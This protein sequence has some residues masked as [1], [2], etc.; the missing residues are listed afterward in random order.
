MSQKIALVTGG[1][2]GIGRA[3]AIEL[4]NQGYQVFIT[5]RKEVELL[6][7]KNSAKNPENI[8][9]IVVDFNKSGFEKEI[10]SFIKKSVGE[11]VKIDRLIHCAAI[12]GPIDKLKN[13]ESRLAESMHVNAYA[14][15]ILTHELLPLCNPNT[16]G[17]F[18][19]SNFM[20]P[21]KITPFI[22]IFGAYISSKIVLLTCIILSYPF[23]KGKISIEIPTLAPV[24]DTIIY[25]YFLIKRLQILVNNSQKIKSSLDQ[26]KST[27]LKDETLK[28]AP[29]NK[30][31]TEVVT[32]IKN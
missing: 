26:E 15:L 28:Q 2:S 22:D 10:P 5:A 8:I 19:S 13:L 32:F 11:Y 21:A 20:K 12:I 4:V 29:V 14:P 31:S 18:M 16:R 25:N 3:T 9:S 30:K 1:S 17:S 7:T 23:F 27:K 6:N 24:K